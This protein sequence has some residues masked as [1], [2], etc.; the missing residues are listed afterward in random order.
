MA[1]KK[2]DAKPEPSATAAPKGTIAKAK[3]ATA[4]AAGTV[5]KAVASAVEAVE[6]RVVK[7]VAKAV[8]AGPTPKPKKARYVRPAQGPK[9]DVAPAALPARSTK[10]SGKMMSKGMAL[11]PKDKP[12]GNPGRGSTG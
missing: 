6:E 5:A 3:S 11:P 1:K 8:G 12:A 10:A 9:P 2:K 7:P 4:K